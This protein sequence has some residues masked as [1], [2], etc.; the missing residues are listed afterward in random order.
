LKHTYTFYAYVVFTHGTVFAI[1]IF[2][3]PVQWHANP[4]LNIWGHMQ[5]VIVVKGAGLKEIK[6]QQTVIN[7]SQFYN[8]H[9][10]ILF[11]FF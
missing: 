8:P 1:F 2:F 5:L 6:K 10:V 11:L 3:Y 7:P 4:F 9:F